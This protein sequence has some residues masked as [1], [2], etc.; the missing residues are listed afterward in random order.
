M[1]AQKEANDSAWDAGKDFKKR[2][3][4]RQSGCDV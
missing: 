3:C 1:V 4:L 2:R